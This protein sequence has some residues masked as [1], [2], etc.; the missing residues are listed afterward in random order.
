M[1]RHAVDGK[2]EALLDR[3]VKRLRAIGASPHVIDP[4]SI[5]V[6]FDLDV[7]E[8]GLSRFF[9]AVV[10]LSESRCDV[11]LARRTNDRRKDYK[12]MIIGEGDPVEQRVLDLIVRGA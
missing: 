8:N 2:P 4:A 12:A 10:P 11:A 1:K 9:L 3:I 6:L 5:T 7:P